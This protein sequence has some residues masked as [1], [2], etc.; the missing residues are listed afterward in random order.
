[1]YKYAIDNGFAG[2]CNTRGITDPAQVQGLM[3]V[4]HDL[5]CQANQHIQRQAMEKQALSPEYQGMLIGGLGGAGL[6]AGIGGLLGGWR[7]AGIGLGAGGLG[8]AGLGYMAGGKYDVFREAYNQAK[9]DNQE[10]AESS[11]VVGPTELDLWLEKY[12]TVADAVKG[13]GIAT[14]PLYGIVNKIPPPEE[15]LKEKEI[16]GMSNVEVEQI[17]QMLKD[18]QKQ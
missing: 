1:M 2:R 13:G 11:E 6:G 9:K 10:I 3:K 18:K 5:I 16:Y 7:G 8:G 15:I 4:A 12:N 14:L 17:R